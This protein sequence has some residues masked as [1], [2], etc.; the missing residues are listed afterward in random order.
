MIKIYGKNLY[1][2][3]VYLKEDND[4]TLFW[5]NKQTVPNES[6]F[7]IVKVVWDFFIQRSVWVQACYIESTLE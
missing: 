6:V 4:L 1:N 5:I 3:P 2:S 7:G